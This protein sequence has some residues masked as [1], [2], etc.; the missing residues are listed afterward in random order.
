MSRLASA[1]R[2][3]TAA[4]AARSPPFPQPELATSDAPASTQQTTLRT[5]VLLH[6]GPALPVRT[7][8]G[9]IPRSARTPVAGTGP[10]TTRTRGASPNLKSSFLVISQTRYLYFT[11]TQ[12]GCIDP[13]KPIFRDLRWRCLPRFL[14][15]QRAM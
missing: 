7:R 4:I 10:S 5:A 9:I 14:G 8:G 2:P 15:R 3:A 11:S 12:V 13:I 1:G 6:I